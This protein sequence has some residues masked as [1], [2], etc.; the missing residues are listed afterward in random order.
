MKKGIIFKKWRINE[1]KKLF[2][3]MLCS[4]LILITN[5]VL[6]QNK[7]R[8]FRD[9]NLKFRFLYPP[10][11]IT[12]KP[13]GA[14]VKAS[15]FAPIGFP[16]ANCNI[17]VRSVPETTGLTQKQLNGEISRGGP[18]P[19]AD[20]K[21]MFE[22][23]WPEVNPINSRIVKVDNQPAYL[24]VVEL[25]HETLDRKTFAKNMVLMTFT[26]GYVWVFTCVAKGATIEKSRISFKY[27]Q[28]TFQRIMGSLVFERW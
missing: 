8:T 28:S 25:C 15:F 4:A 5:G 10:D 1:S 9:N 21:K 3:L 6:A 26:P 22:H 19:T 14:N 18:I 20:L 17:V 27:W 2:V 23:K 7:W 12:G 16:R 24:S 13:R 11:W